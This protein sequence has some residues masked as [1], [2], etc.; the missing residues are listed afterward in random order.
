MTVVKPLIAPGDLADNPWRL[1][2][3]RMEGSTSPWLKAY[4][5]RSITLHLE[6]AENLSRELPLLKSPIAPNFMKRLET[7]KALEDEEEAVS[8]EQ[9]AV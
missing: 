8:G 6:L 9:Q 3:D 4:G 7:W 1:I 2:I 5:V